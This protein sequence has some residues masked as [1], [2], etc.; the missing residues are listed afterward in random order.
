MLDRS[1]WEQHTKLLPKPGQSA[2]FEHDCGEGRVLKVAHADHGY[3]A[4]CFRCGDSGFI[5][6]PAPS[7]SERLARLEAQR[8]AEARV[9]SSVE[10]PAPANVDPHA[11]G[12]PLAA[13]VWLYKAGLSNDDIMRLGAYYHEPTGRVILPVY[14]DGRAV[15]WQGRDPTWK[16]GSPKIKYINPPVDKSQLCA[17]YG[18]GPVIV[19]TE[20][21]L[22]AFRV[23]R[24]T[25]AWSLLGTAL[26]SGVLADLI[27]QGKPV[28]LMLDPDAGGQKATTKIVQKLRMLGVPVSI[29]LPHRDPKYLTKEETLSCLIASNPVLLGPLLAPC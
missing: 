16:R 15:Y 28:V 27:A 25:E 26:A 22:S 1:T 29:A 5:P 12:W 4:W 24:V 9:S 2:R 21:I 3:T 6:H 19:L 23:S 10:L 11:G 8:N 18:A 7:L 20:D 14:K 13:R 17:K